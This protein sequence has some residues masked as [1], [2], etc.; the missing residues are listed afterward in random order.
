MV[1]KSSMFPES[2][3][4]VVGVILK[5]NTDSMPSWRVFKICHITLSS[6]SLSLPEFLK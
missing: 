5:P 2:I 1:S 4:K 3:G 6:E